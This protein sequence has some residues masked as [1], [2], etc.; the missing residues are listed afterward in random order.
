MAMPAST[1]V[2]ELQHVDKVFPGVKALSDVSL[3][4]QKGEI[5]GLIGPNGSGKSTMI[6]T[7]MGNYR[8]DAGRILFEGSDLAGLTVWDRVRR[9]INWTNQT[10]TYVPDLSIRRHIELGVDVNGYPKEDVER[11]AET[12]DLR[13]TLDELPTALSAVGAKKLE[14]GKVL[15][16]RPS[17]LMLD[18]CFAGLS[19]E[20]GEEMVGII[21][22]I[23]D[24]HDMTVL[25]VDH[26]LALVE[27]VAQITTV[28]DRGS[29]I[30]EGP[31]QD[32]VDNPVVVEAY[33]G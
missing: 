28:I 9:G 5:R 4:V 12:V 29:L 23:V 18:E 8:P 33:M 21:K 11:V 2:L 17:F 32:I 26:N 1:P 25:V 14:L 24:E 15:T 16:T 10:A 7:I 20:E 19:F 27:Q 31:F 3:S 13:D 30:A 6:A 22:T